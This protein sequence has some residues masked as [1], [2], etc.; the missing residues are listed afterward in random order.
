MIKTNLYV[1]RQRRLVRAMRGNRLDALLVWDRANTRYLSGFE[2]SAS[3]I[4]LTARR[5]YFLTDFRY[6]TV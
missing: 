4:Y 6:I 5:G 2:G 1:V 3:V